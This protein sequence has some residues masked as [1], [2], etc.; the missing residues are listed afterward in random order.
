MAAMQAPTDRRPGPGLALMLAA[1]AG[2]GG[3]LWWGQNIAGH[4]GGQISLQKVFWFCLAVTMFVWM[5][6]FLWLDRR[7]APV[8]RT[9]FAVH[10]VLWAVRVVAELWLCYGV[11][12]WIPPYGMAHNLTTLAIVGILVARHRVALA[13]FH[14]RPTRNALRY[15]GFMGIAIVC[16][17]VF[18]GLFYATVNYD[19]THIWFANTEPRFGLINQLTLVADLVLYPLLFLTVRDYYRPDAAPDAPEAPAA[20]PQSLGG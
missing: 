18:A 13:T 11:H 2:V 3:Y 5:P 14:D 15:L 8:L 4:D 1:M 20:R 7:V 19:T 16:E 6:L 10:V 17:C 12:R 9:I